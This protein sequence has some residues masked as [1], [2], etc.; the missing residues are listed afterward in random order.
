MTSEKGN[1]RH[2]AIVQG[3]KNYV[4][5]HDLSGYF[6]ARAGRL[7]KDMISANN[8]ARRRAPKGTHG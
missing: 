3:H 5:T 8:D 2:I 7:A 4:G 6:A 1:T